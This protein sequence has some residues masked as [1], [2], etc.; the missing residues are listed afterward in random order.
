MHPK[1][2][3]LNM[4]KLVYAL[5]ALSLVAFVGCKKD[6]DKQKEVTT[7]NL[8]GT[9]ELYK[10]YDKEEGWDTEYGSKYGYQWQ[11][12]FR[13]DLTGTSVEID[14]DGTFEQAFTYNVENG[15]IKLNYNGYT[16]RIH[17]KSLTQNELVTG[18]GENYAEYFKRVK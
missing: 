11:V 13:A 7:A 12:T 16:D 6:D 5:L 17:V 14:D 9:W 2:H 1:N 10:T 18:S 4:K 15:V 8:V 3:R